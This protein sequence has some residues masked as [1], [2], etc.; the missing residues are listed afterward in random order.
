MSAAPLSAVRTDS[1]LVPVLR[2]Q[3]KDALM[4]AASHTGG[5][6]ELHVPESVMAMVGH[7]R[8][9]AAQTLALADTVS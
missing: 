1:D 6:S 7:V 5:V 2:D 3:S 8:C 4:P 9:N